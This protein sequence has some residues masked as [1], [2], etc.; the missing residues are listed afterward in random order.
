MQSDTKKKPSPLIEILVNV[1]IPSVILMKFSGPERLGTVN[2][3]VIALAFPIIYGG[4]DLVRN[5]HVNYIAILGLVSIMLTGGIGLLK[6][7]VRWLAIKEAAIPAL[8]GIAVVIT[9]FTRS[10]LVK[11]LIFNPLVMATGK[12]QETLEK[13]RKQELFDRKLRFANH[14]LAGTFAFSAVMN[15]ILAKVIVTSE[16]GTVAF[17]EELGKMT[18]LSYPMIAIP[19]MLMLFGIMWYVIRTIRK[20]TGFGLEE[21]FHHGD[22]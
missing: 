14:C 19:S 4:Y 8:I 10:P 13:E 3:L 12:I 2:A 16:T 9:G 7:D 6:L 22:G 5:R 17:N 1:L 20:L 11:K 18:F 21:I 15:Y